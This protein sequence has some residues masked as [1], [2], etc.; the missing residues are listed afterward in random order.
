M[1]WKCECEYLTES[2]VVHMMYSHS[3]IDDNHVRNIILPLPS[4]QLSSTMAAKWFSGNINK[5]QG[6]NFSHIRA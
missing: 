1:N 5:Y 3:K 4:T 6:C 2:V